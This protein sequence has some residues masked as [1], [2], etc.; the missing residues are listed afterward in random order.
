MSP[1][2]WTQPA[3]W[4]PPGSHEP[5]TF[6]FTSSLF[7]L[8]I[9]IRT[10]LTQQSIKNFTVRTQITKEGILLA[11]CDLVRFFFFLFFVV[12]ILLIYT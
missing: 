3:G 12:L 9:W 5:R 6:F 8:I 4:Q 11:T 1:K 10:L 2:G 7:V